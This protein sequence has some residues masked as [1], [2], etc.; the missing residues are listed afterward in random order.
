MEEGE[1]DRSVGQEDATVEEGAGKT[2]SVRGTQLATSGFE[3]VQRAINQ[4][5]PRALGA[6]N[7][8]QLTASKGTGTSVLQQQ[9]VDFC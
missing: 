3:G 9:A 6:E 5:M 4:G 1:K 2:G 7:D 8:P